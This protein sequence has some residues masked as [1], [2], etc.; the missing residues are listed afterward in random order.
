MTRIGSH[1]YEVVEYL[2]STET[3]DSA[4]PRQGHAGYLLQGVADWLHADERNNNR[5]HGDPVLELHNNT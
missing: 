3:L 1:E 2:V 5:V 4:L